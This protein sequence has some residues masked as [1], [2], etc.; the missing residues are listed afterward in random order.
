MI[1]RTLT[2]QFLRQVRV[3]HLKRR[4]YYLDFPM[5]GFPHMFRAWCTQK[6]AG[7]IFVTLY[8]PF[9]D[10]FRRVP[11]RKCKCFDVSLTSIALIGMTFL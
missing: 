6:R 8:R 9:P 4:V 11:I 10:A 1:T 7:K 3:V 2:A 5:N